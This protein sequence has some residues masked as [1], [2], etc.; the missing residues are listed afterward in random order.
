MSV[1]VYAMTCGWVTMPMNSLLSGEEGTLLVPVPSY[2]ID[3]PKGAVLFDTGLHLDIFTDKAGYLGKM[4]KWLD[5]TFHPGDEL[6]ARLETMDHD[7][8]KIETVIVSHLHFD[9]CGGNAQ[10]PNARIIVQAKEWA[11]GHEPDFIRTNGYKREDYDLGHDVLQIE[12]EYDVFGDNS[13]V[14]IPTYGHTPGH[15]SLLVRTDAGEVVLAGDACYLRQTL[16]KMWLPRQVHDKEAMLASLEILAGLKARGA[17]I[18]YGH[19]P[20]FWKD[21]PQAPAAVA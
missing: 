11:A 14:C 12:G 21:V 1:Q 4:A 9:H 7:A 5:V 2:L 6:S 16:E 3:H 18:F 8:G 20:E 13:V 15:Q 17:R 10:A 19:D